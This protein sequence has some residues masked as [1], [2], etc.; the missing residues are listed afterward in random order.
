MK[1]ILLSIAFSIC[2]YWLPAQFI[3]KI[4]ADSVLITNDSC[5]AELNLESSTKHVL[6]F[7]YNKGMGRTEFRRGAIKINDSM[8]LVGADTI[9]TMSGGSG[10]YIQNQIIA[11]QLASFRISGSGQLGNYLRLGNLS[12]DPTGSNGMIFYNTNRQQFRGYKNGL[13]KNMLFRGDIEVGSGL[14]LHPYFQANYETDLI[15]LGRQAFDGSTSGHLT[16]DTWLPLNNY[17]FGFTRGLNDGANVDPHVAV[18]RSSLIV[19]GS[20]PAWDTLGQSGTNG[21]PLLTIGAI[22]Y[23][24]NR[25]PYFPIYGK[26]LIDIWIPK[27]NNGTELT[28]QRMHSLTDTSTSPDFYYAIIKGLDI[29][30]GLN[31]YYDNSANKIIGIRTKVYQ[32]STNPG[33]SKKSLYAISSE[34]GRNYFADSVMLGTTNPGAFFHVNGTTRFD[35]GSDAIGDIFYRNSS[36][37]FTRLPIGTSGQVLS[38]SSGL[39]AWAAPS[40]GGGNYIENQTAIDQ[41]AS[42]RISGSGLIKGGISSTLT[43]G[44]RNER[45]GAGALNSLTVTSTDNTALG[46]V[47]LNSFNNNSGGGNTA[48][49]SYALASLTTGGSQTAIGAGALYNNISTIGTNTAIGNG[50]IQ[51]SVGSTAH[52]NVGV[53]YQTLFNITSGNSNIALGTYASS[54]VTTGVQNINIGGGGLSSGANYNV[55]VGSATLGSTSGSFNVALGQQA[56]ASLTTGSSNIGV[57]YGA[58]GGITTGVN[59]VSV[60]QAAGGTN[61]GS[62][63]V[64]LGYQAGYYNTGSGNIFIGKTAGHTETASN[65]LYIENSSTAIPLIYGDF[66]ND[67]VRINGKFHA[68]GPAKFDLGSDAT[69]DIFY[70]NSLGQF[71]R[72]PIGTSGQVLSVSS[73]LPGWAASSGGGGV[74]KAEDVSFHSDATASITMT[75]QANSEQYLANNARNQLWFDASGYDSVRLI[76]N[77]TT[78]SAS[79]N[80][81][82][83][84]IQYSSNGTTWTTIGTGT[85]TQVVSLATPADLKKT[86]WIILPAGAKT[87]IRFRVTQHGGDGVADPVVG[88]VSIQFK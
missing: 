46:Y 1:K 36:G 33:E 77:V 67:T 17:Y 53:G 10:S 62:D 47:A 86:S 88:K 11:D 13:W 66:A 7:L 20:V 3:H 45:F 73:G 75:N 68:N 51:G 27:P 29:E 40:G 39:P 38:V 65:K 76:A 5:T 31:S 4:K 18:T 19:G 63:N 85:G 83:L 23:S 52:N 37:Q 54:A 79:V 12:A 30:L 84:Y 26:R 72:L 71:T 8:Y 60:G 78:T 41:P 61:N 32:K 34:G 15:E 16:R 2:T 56:L 9:R 42:F 6:G 69:G 55:G 35:I 58:G 87:D 57:G 70:R 64:F 48:V 21:R 43:V 44:E 25:M 74:S 59:N 80:T 22:D 49:G 14:R 81:P 28:L 50:A 24:G 82:R